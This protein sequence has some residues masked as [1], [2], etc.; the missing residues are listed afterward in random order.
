VP[1]RLFVRCHGALL[2]L[3]TRTI[4]RVVLSEEACALVRPDLAAPAPAGEADLPPVR[5]GTTTY[6]AWDLARMLG[7][8]EVRTS[9]VLLLHPGPRGS[10]PLALRTG[11]CV[12]VSDLSPATVRL[13]EDLFRERASALRAVF[14]L[15]G[16]PETSG[17]RVGFE[18]SLDALWSPAEIAF[19]EATLAALEPSA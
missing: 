6:A 7:L 10:L 4:E 13:P 9:Y 1:L 11:P 14:P 8:P 3:D 16:R 17:T 19:A 2:A 12:N 15:E 18:L 5:V